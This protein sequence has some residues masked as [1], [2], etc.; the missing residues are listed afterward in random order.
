MKVRHYISILAILGLGAAVMI[1]VEACS[2]N[3]PQTAQPVEDIKVFV[4]TST[5]KPA[6]D[7]ELPDLAGGTQKLS[8]YR[9]K[10]VIVN[11][12]ATWCGPCKY[13]IP[14]FIKL[15]NA[16]KDKGMTILGISIGEQKSTVEAFAKAK[17]MVYPVLIDTRSSVPGAYGGVRGIPTTFIITQDGKIYRKHVGVPQ[18]MAIFEEEVKTLLGIQTQNQ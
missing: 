15:Y 11:F 12:W 10:V 17:G 6:P 1:P 4:D 9:G 18:D 16:S 2:D 3:K 8:A 13:E 14:H 7:F 5:L